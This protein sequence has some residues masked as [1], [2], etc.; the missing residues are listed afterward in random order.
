MAKKKDRKSAR[1]AR[2]AARRATRDSDRTEYERLAHEVRSKMGKLEAKR[3]DYWA[4]DYLTR[5]LGIENSRQLPTFET[6]KKAQIKAM[7]AFLKQKSSTLRGISNIRKKQLE[8]LERNASERLGKRVK[9][10]NTALLFAMFDSEDSKKWKEQMGSTEFV[11]K[12][13]ELA[14][15]NYSFDAIMAAFQ[16]YNDREIGYSEIA[17]YAKH[18]NVIYR[19]G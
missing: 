18:Y 11:D 13:L 10:T 7:Q 19:E 16:D 1:L 6:A 3:V 15:E 14:E 17:D 5:K 2:R 4:Y 9:I 8:S 12:F